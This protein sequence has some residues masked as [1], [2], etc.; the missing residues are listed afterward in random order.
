MG[1]YNDQICAYSRPDLGFD[2]IDALPIKR[3]VSLGFLV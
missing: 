2:C 1:N 3:L